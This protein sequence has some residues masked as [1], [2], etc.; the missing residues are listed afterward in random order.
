MGKRSIR[1]SSIR[2]PKFGIIFAVRFAIALAVFSLIAVY[3]LKQLDDKLWYYCS[4]VRQDY[5][6]NV[7]NTTTSL[8]KDKPGAK[9]IMTI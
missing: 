2:K 8:A 4:P 6:D 3:L 1:K 7:V 5:L 9:I